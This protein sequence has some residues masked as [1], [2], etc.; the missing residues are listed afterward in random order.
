[1]VDS[2]GAYVLGL[3]FLRRRKSSLI[4]GA[5]ADARAL[6]AHLEAY[7]AG[8]TRDDDSTASTSFRAA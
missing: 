4:D 1:V 5:G 6:S 3:P 7:L 8:A 2:P